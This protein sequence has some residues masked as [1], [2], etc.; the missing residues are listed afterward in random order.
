[1]Y[2]LSPETVKPGCTDSELVQARIASGTFF[3]VDPETY[4]AELLEAM[5]KREA[6]NTTMELPTG[7]TIA[8][9]SQPTP[10]GNGWVVTHEDITDRRRTEMERDRSQAFANVV[11]E[12]V[13]ATIVLK[14]ARTLRYVLINRA[15][16]EY[17]GIPRKAMIGKLAEQLFPKETADTI[18]EHDRQLLS[19]GEPQ[20]YDE[21]PMNT[22]SG[23]MRIATTTR[24][25]ISDEH[26]GVCNTSSHVMEDR[27]RSKTRGGPDRTLV[28][29]D[30]LT[31]FAQPRRV[32]G[33]HRG[34]HRDCGQRGSIVR[35]DVPRL[36]PLQGGQRRLRPRRRR[37]NAAPTLD[38]PAGRRG[39]AFLA[40]LGGDEFVVIATDG[41][42]PA[43]AAAMADR[44]LAAASEEIPIEGYSVRA[45]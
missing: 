32:H 4:I 2:G 25:P 30:L 33:L 44:L 14:D 22:P 43:A 1:M 42:R 41:E 35:A 10:D 23:G 34:D 27:N 31:R 37:R 24:I 19:S 6:G 11:I 13:P 20:F 9:I 18:I 15:G 5:R 36:R 38:A 45:G 21:R 26:G 3:A 16:E 28:H 8:V 12:N 17:F 39:R 29:H 40:R 7:R